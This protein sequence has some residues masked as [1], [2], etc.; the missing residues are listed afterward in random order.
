MATGH[1]QV[2]ALILEAGIYRIEHAFPVSSREP[3]NP[4]LLNKFGLDRTY[5]LLVPTG[6]NIPKLARRFAQLPGVEYAEPD[7]VG[8]G[9]ATF[10]NDTHFGLQDGLHQT[11]DA[12]MDAPEAW[13]LTVGNANVIIAVLDTGADS[14]HEDFAG[15]LLPGYDFANNDADP[16]DDQGHGSNV[17]SVAAAATNNAL[18]IAGACWNCRIMP[19]KVL[20]STNLGFYSWW[21]DAMIW[22]ADNGADLINGSIGGTSPSTTLFNG[23]RY[24]WEAGVPHI[25]ITHNDNT[26]AIRYPGR[27]AETIT[28]GATN[29]I[30]QHA[31]PF[32]WGGGS[33]WGPEIDVV[34]PGD[35]IPGIAMGGGYSYW[36][37]TSQAAPLVAGL[38]GLMMSVYPS[39]GRE[40]MR[41]LLHAGAEDQ[42]GLLP[43]DTVGFDHYYGWGRVNMEQ[44]L[45]GTLASTT[46]RVEGKVATRPFLETANPLATSYDFIRGDLGALTEGRAG[47]ATGSVTC[48]ENDSP[49]GDTF[50]NEDTSSPASGAAF[51]Y[52]ARFNSVA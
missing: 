31:V 11:S 45:L 51:F 35:M 37:G 13:D 15:K 21:T 24:A 30:D 49:D 23:V 43:E 19:L 41:H 5:K 50:G 42:V 22:A 44:T 52:L 18:G 48:L 33:N 6:S 38:G 17:A 8:E 46:L 27:Y 36:C 12:D 25:S 1:S 20:D 40:E 7:F 29:N 2:D 14:D 34:A 9:G 28:V 32:C 26:S 4:A 3:D 47:V 10:P 16:E 39:I